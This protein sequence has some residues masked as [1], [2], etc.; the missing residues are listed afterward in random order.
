MNKNAFVKLTMKIMAGYWKNTNF[1][2]FHIWKIMYVCNTP[3]NF[4]EETLSV[5]QITSFRLLA[6]SVCCQVVVLC[7][8]LFVQSPC[9]KG[10]I[11]QHV[12]CTK[13]MKFSIKDFLDK[14][15]KNCSFL[16]IWSRLLKESLMEN[17]IFCAAA[18][19]HA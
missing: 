5:S 8:K 9:F 6:L 3:R 15:D 16:R 4:K 14:C 19:V 10:I 18:L 2:I 12:H 11:H 7:E 1:L 13:E 17:S